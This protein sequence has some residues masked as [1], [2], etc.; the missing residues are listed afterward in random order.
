MKKSH[1]SFNQGHLYISGL[2]NPHMGA[3]LLVTSTPTDTS[4]AILGE[5]KASK[6]DE[7]TLMLLL[8]LRSLL[9]K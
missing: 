4:G 5:S 7:F 1:H 9:L 6:L 8:P 3:H 2:I